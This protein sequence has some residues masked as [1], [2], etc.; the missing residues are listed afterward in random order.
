VRQ[1]AEEKINQDKQLGTEFR[2]RFSEYFLNFV[3]ARVIRSQPNVRYWNALVSRRMLEVDPEW[4]SIQE[5]M[6]YAEEAGQEESMSEFVLLL[7]H[8]M[9]CRFY[10]SERL[11]YVQ[12]AIDILKSRNRKHDEALLRIDALGWTYMEENLL[13]KADDSIKSGLEIVA[14]CS[15]PEWEDLRVLGLAWQARIWLERSPDSDKASELIR[16]ALDIQCR[17]WIRSRVLMVAGDNAL[18]H[19]NKADAL[20]RYQ[21]SACEAGKY[22]GGGEYQIYSRIGLAYL[23]AGK[24]G[25]AKR[26]FSDLLETSTSHCIEIGKLYAQF[27]LA[28]I[29]RKHDEPNSAVAYI[30]NI[31]NELLKRERPNH[32]LL[33]MINEV[34]EERRTAERRQYPTH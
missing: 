16:T 25:M 15:G 6:K 9:D 13:D 30:A 1:F 24:M 4:P 21:E 20:R 12:K 27:G 22:D 28:I 34:Y 19:G 18:K 33:K 32:L 31:R 2:R 29:A 11:A 3:R 5:A 26:T 10:T 23:D 14:Q 7:I 17:P 8:Y